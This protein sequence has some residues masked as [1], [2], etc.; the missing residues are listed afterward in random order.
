MQQVPESERLEQKCPLVSKTAR[1]ICR[2]ASCDF[3]QPA[4]AACAVGLGAGAAPPSGRCGA[5][6]CALHLADS[7][8]AFAGAAAV[9][10]RFGTAA[11]PAKASEES[12]FFR[13]G[14]GWQSD[15]AVGHGKLLGK[16][17]QRTAAHFMDRWVQHH[18]LRNRQRLGWQAWGW[19]RDT[20][21]EAVFLQ[22]P[23]ACDCSDGFVG[24]AGL[25]FGKTNAFEL[26]QCKINFSFKF[27]GLHGFFVMQ[28][29]DLRCK[30]Q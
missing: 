29:A 2:L 10:T 15:M 17:V 25:I 8:L 24:L 23:A 7:S 19:Q 22:R 14:V 12:A 6:C 4:A 21:G 9:F 28:K 1:W 26:L 11:A 3:W 5:W 16:S 27:N 18:P 13:G 30:S 20:V